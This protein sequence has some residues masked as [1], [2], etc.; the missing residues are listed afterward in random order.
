[1]KENMLC[2]WVRVIQWAKR[3][4]ILPYSQG[5]ITVCPFYFMT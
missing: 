3:K 4:E 2:P 1:M 5:F